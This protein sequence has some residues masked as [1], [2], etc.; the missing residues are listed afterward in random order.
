MSNEM[1]QAIARFVESCIGENLDHLISMDMRGDGIS[2]LLMA[3]ARKSVGAPLTQT[4]ASRLRDALGDRDRVLML[5]GFIVS[6]WNVGETDGLIGT[7]VLGRALE[8]ALNVQPI[9]VCEPEIF[10]PLE[11]GFRAAGLLVFYS[12]E[13]ARDLPHSV[14]LL[15]FPKD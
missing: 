15:P 13:D 3:A 6:P 5:T 12:F 2:R 14:V 8:V 9:V 4:A 10:P 11:A 7:I 1:E